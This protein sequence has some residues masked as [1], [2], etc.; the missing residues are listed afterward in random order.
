MLRTT[1]LVDGFNVY[2]SLCQASE[3]LAFSGAA[4]CSTRWLDLRGLFQ[5]LISSGIGPGLRQK[6]EL[7]DIF[8]FSALPNHKSAQTIERHKNYIR[9]LESTGVKVELGRFKMK[10]VWCSGCRQSTRHWEEK[11]SD[12]A[13]SVRLA[14]IALRGKCD[15]AVL[16][17]GDTDIAPAVRMVR[18]IAPDLK[19][20]LAFPYRRKNDELGVL[21]DF[22]LNITKKNYL[23][24]QFAQPVTL[25]DGSEI[26]KPSHW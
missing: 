22:S 9:C 14:E 13:I 23:K 24:H 15:V 17:T 11:E 26:Q 18:D 4:N 1:F 25:Q 20:V 10:D 12:V 21:A 2:H 19:I 6:A 5:N 3:D 8:Y 16:V 7:C